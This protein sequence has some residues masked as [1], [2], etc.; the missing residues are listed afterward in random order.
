MILK[1]MFVN[2]VSIKIYNNVAI[3]DG[4]AGRQYFMKR[5]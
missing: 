3:C 1:N 4:Y 2:L 5:A